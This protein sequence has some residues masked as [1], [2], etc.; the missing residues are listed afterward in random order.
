MVSA[1]LRDDGYGQRIHADVAR[2]DM[3]QDFRFGGIAFGLCGNERDDI[4]S[5]EAEAALRIGQVLAH[6]PGQQ[7]AHDSVHVPAK[8][9]DCRRMRDAVAYNHRYAGA[10]VCVNEPRNVGRIVLPVGV[11]RDDDVESPCAGVL[12]PG[13]DRV[14]RPL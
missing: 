12:E 8:E 13:I 1:A 9:W 2:G 14:S 10:N 3:E 7:V 5:V 11:E 6:L 4:A